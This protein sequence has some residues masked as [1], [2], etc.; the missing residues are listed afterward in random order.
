M[1]H[2]SLYF[3]VV[4][5]VLVHWVVGKSRFSWYFDLPPT[6]AVKPRASSVCLSDYQLLLL[7]L[8][9]LKGLAPKVN[10]ALFPRRNKALLSSLMSRCETCAV[11]RAPITAV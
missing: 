5:L 3:H 11:R 10:R 7:L 8:L 9:L 1:H 6:G 4:S 2:Q